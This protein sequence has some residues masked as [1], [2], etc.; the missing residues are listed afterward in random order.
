MHY[1]FSY[2]NPQRH[3]IHIACIISE[4][5]SDTLKV[6]LPSWRPGRYELGN[7][8]KNIQK[9][10]V[11]D[12]EGNKLQSK[13]LSKDLWEIA[14][15]EV[16][17]V[18]I[19]YTYYAAEINA[20]S[21]YLDEH[22]LYVNP[23]NCCIYVPDR[24]H[25]P[26]EVELIIPE[27][28]QV[29]TGL[30]PSGNNKF[31]AGDFHE[32]ADSP[33]IASK[34]LKRNETVVGGTKFHLSFQ[35]ECNPDWTRLLKDFNTFIGVQISTM[36]KF[37]VPEYHFLFQILPHRIYHG[38]EH[39]GSTVIALGPS[40]DL[41]EN[42][43]Y[44]QL[45]GISCHELYHSW[46][47]KS[48]RPVEMM[49]YDY[50]RENYSRLGYVCEGVTTYYGDYFLFR[51]GVFNVE[52]YFRRFNERLQKH[53]HNPARFTMPVT[54]ASFDTWL[55]GYV[56]GIPARKTSIYDEGCLLAFMTDMQIRRKTG[57]EKSLD[58][59]M[60]ALYL[61]FSLQGKG[62]SEQDYM[63]VVASFTG[64]SIVS[65]FSDYVYGTQ[66]YEPLL[67]E[68]L[69]YIGCELVKTESKKHHEARYGFKLT[70]SSLPP[71]ISMIYPGSLSDKAGL[72]ENDELIAINSH[73]IKNDFN[74]WERFFA[75]GSVQLTVLSNNLVKNVKLLSSGCEQ[76]YNYG[77]ARLK[78]PTQNQAKA[79]ANWTGQKF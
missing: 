62:Y 3:F 43:G 21:C 17:V 49:P 28:Y 52:E 23:V 57:D 16:S 39:L 32:L 71:K 42:N 31:S 73:A 22:Q 44:N 48:I 13:K 74:E 10:E 47:I 56:P 6:Q 53:F 60:R 65:F 75:G 1:I 11:F 34:T 46:N 68:Q 59:V 26:C 76:Y 2:Q 25:L 40:Y 41:M 78:N 15:V 79:Y 72:A 77:I 18:H 69:D 54:E 14:T 67:R 8:A 61:D 33:F 63:N 58:D 36:K 51:S 38:V 55:D 19:H 50:T 29:A 12:S 66:D 24:I 64:G 27:D 4:I 70:E 37:P 9:W 45:L 5:N 35:G 30:K 20:G 7:F